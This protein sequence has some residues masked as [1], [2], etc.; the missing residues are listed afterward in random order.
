M[1]RRPHG[2]GSLF[3]K[4]EA[5]YGQWRADGRL[6]KRKLGSV[7]AVGTRE[8]LT[9]A[10]AETRLRE[11]MLSL[12]VVTDETARVSLEELGYRYV[13]HADTV[14][15]RKATTVQDYRIMIR[16]HF[17]P[18]FGDTVVDEL[19]GRDVERYMRAKRV[20]GLAFKTIR[21]HTSLLHAIFEFGVRRDVLRENPMRRMDRIP[22]PAVDAD[23]RFITLEELEALVEGVPSGPFYV[24]DRAI[25][26]AAAM[27]GLRQGEL[28][29]L[30]WRDVDR[31][32][33]VLRVRRTYTR[34]AFSTPKTRRATR[35]VP[36][37]DRVASELRQLG[38]TAAFSH[39]D[40]LVFG[41]PQLG[42]VL[43]PSSLRKRMAIALHAA[44]VRQIRFHD[45][46][47]T[48]GTLMA[49][50]GAP[51]RLLQEWMGHRDYK[52]TLIYA[53]YAPDLAQGAR[54]AARAFGRDG[55]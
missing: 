23:I 35:A 51:M 19:K 13:D 25:Y 14:L 41:H 42:S 40:D 54:Y 16:R 48:Y 37:A 30:R 21:N 33:G 22:S 27:T 6:V 53:D 55:E 12:R 2:T 9:I 32:A 38:E 39:D 3:R 11:L 5:W 47:H 43:D 26:V 4:G 34:G 18:F 15:L 44:G 7:R 29:A 17:V 24:V 31:S 46:R 52:T 10:M 28:L 1:T 45:L 50:A 49:G 36:M 8:G 20:D